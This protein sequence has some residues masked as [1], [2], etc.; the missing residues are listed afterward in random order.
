MDFAVLERGDQPR[1]RRY[2]HGHPLPFTDANG[3]SWARDH[4]HRMAT[5]TR[6]DGDDQ[7]GRICLCYGDRLVDLNR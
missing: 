5:P 2:C 3:V 6:L 7:H 1:N 4:Y